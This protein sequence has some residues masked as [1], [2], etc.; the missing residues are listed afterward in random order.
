MRDRREH[1]GILYTFCYNNN[2]IHSPL[3]KITVL[4]IE[5]QFYHYRKKCN[6]KERTYKN[7]PRENSVRGRERERDRGSID[8]NGGWIEGNKIKIISPSNPLPAHSR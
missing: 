3:L 7:L 6:P 1:T 8:I 5:R 2:N 4:V